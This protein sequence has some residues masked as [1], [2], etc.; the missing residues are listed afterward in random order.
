[1]AIQPPDP[2]TPPK[3]PPSGA[4]RDELQMYDIML[5]LYDIQKRLHKLQVKAMK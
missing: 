5:V 1:M 4:T 2:P 3:P